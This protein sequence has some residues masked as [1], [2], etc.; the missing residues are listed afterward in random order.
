MV[1]KKQITKRSAYFDDGAP[2]KPSC[3]AKD[4][5]SIYHYFKDLLHPK[6]PF[7]PLTRDEIAQDIEDLL[8]EEDKRRHLKILYMI[9]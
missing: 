7:H 2:S 9:K 6:P 8:D 5:N 3:V 1:C 4:A